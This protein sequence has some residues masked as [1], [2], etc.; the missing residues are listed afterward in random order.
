[1]KETKGISPKGLF[2]A[3]LLILV[4]AVLVMVSNFISGQKKQ[5]AEVNAET[6]AQDVQNSS[7]CQRNPEEP[8]CEQSRRILE[9]ST[10]AIPGPAGKD[11][12]DGINGL[13]G[14]R[15]VPGQKGD[16]GARGLQGLG[17]DGV[18]GEPGTD[19]VDGQ[20]GLD[21]AA[22]R[23]GIDGQAG[24]DGAPGLNGAD[25][26]PGQ[27]GRDGA[28][29][30][31]APTITEANLDCLAGT[32]TLTMSE[33]PA[34]VG[35]ATCLPGPQGPEGPVGPAG[36]EGAEGE[37]GEDGEDSVLAPGNGLIPSP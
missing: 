33:G 37:P 32:I 4:G 9:D 22:G 35:T 34:V 25:G 14:Q 16:T 19:G 28:P 8:L 20:D 11:G 5:T 30:T 24:A 21:G 27:D 15:G 6:Q 23:D 12:R 10:E 1:M 7:I 3:I 2:V 26:A 31:P 36:P 13:N 17:Q 18:D 29:G